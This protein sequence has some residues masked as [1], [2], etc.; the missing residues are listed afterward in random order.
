MPAQVVSFLRRARPL[1]RDWSQDELAEFYRVESALLQAG[2]RIET[3]RGL[4][5]E[6]DPWFA[7]CRADD[8]ETFIHFARIDGRYIIAGPAYEGVAQGYDFPEL[9]RDLISRHP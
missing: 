6:G 8:G 7:F 3:D 4:T 2:M 5:D 1:S 9:V